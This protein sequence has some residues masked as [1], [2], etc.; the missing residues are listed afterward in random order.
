MTCNSRIPS[1]IAAQTQQSC[2]EACRNF[3][4]DPF[5][6]LEPK[7]TR[8]WWAETYTDF[9]EELALNIRHQLE[10]SI[11]TSSECLTMTG[12][13][14]T[15]TASQPQRIFWR[16]RRQKVYQ[17]VAWGISGELPMKRSVVRHKCHNRLCIHPAHLTI[18]T[19]AQNLL[20]QRFRRADD[21]PHL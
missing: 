10:K 4:G 16:G 21:W 11:L 18:G 15:T 13:N 1:L 6:D 7:K 19:Q 2:L 20:D 3:D 5:P 8:A 9:S 14:G 12:R 17:L